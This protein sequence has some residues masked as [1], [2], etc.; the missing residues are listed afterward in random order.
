MRELE[1][2]TEKR[3]ERRTQ[4]INLVK[5]RIQKLPHPLFLRLFY[6]WFFFR[7]ALRAEYVRRKAGLPLLS[8]VDLKK[9]KR[10]DVLFILGT[11]PSINQ[12][13]A[14]RWQAISQ[15]DTLAVNF[16]L[17]H[18]FVPTFYVVESSSYGGLRD[19]VSRRITEVANRR[20][21]EYGDTVKIIT[22]LYQPG[23]QWVFDLDR[24]FR[25]NLHV[26]YDLPVP[27][28][29]EEELE[30][31]I[32]YLLDKGA[33]DAA[34]RLRILF[35]Y[36]Q[37]LSLLLSFAFRLRYRKVV[38]CGIELN[39]DGH[40]YD[41]PELYPEAAWAKD[42]SRDNSSSWRYDDRFQ[43]GI[44]QSSV[45]CL[46]KRLLFDPAGVQLYVENRSSALWP[47]LPEAP[48]D[49]FADEKGERYA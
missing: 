11:G 4:M 9:Y 25:K 3:V 44:R 30:D 22:D 15:H 47:R 40:F 18:S 19:T 12:I 49:L 17:Y 1:V 41:D 27:A 48:A 8:M 23:R 14:Q 37:S 42:D 35:K 16:W 43:W 38:L 28:R 33:F 7:K 5:K 20:G 13:S 6:V 39:T 29:T 46:M 32:R 24:A 36:G 34:T 31:G 21:A 26:A 10:S 2:G 45:A